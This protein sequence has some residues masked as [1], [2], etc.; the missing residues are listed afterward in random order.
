MHRQ[1]FHEKTTVGHCPYC[2]KPV[3]SLEAHVHDKHRTAKKKK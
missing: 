1:K 3:K 2:N